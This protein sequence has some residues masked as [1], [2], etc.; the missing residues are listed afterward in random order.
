MQTATIIGIEAGTIS[1][2]LTNTTSYVVPASTGAV[3]TQ[4]F[5]AN[6]S[7]A[8]VSV[9]VYVS[10]GTTNY[11]LCVN[12]PVAVGDTLDVLGANKLTLA[13]GWYVASSCSAAT[14]ATL[15]MSVT[16]FV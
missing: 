10:N 12:A 16:Q 13:A 7:G 2:T 1:T 3:I 5:A 11:A 9:S 15:T 8:A 6:T 4:L 14:S